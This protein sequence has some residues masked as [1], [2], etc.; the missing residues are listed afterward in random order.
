MESGGH[1]DISPLT[2]TG[3]VLCPKVKISKA[4]L[5]FGECH[6][7]DHKESPFIVENLYTLPIDVKVPRIPGFFVEPPSLTVQ[8]GTKASFVATFQP[9]TVGKFKTAINV[10]LIGGEYKIPINVTGDATNFLDTK[11]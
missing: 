2:L 1:K 3:K 7:H 5:N 4:L 6:V 9:T 8:P 10:T 11:R